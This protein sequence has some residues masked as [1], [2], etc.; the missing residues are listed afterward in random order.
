MDHDLYINLPDGYS[1]QGKVRKLNKAL[2]GLPEAARVWHED[3]EEKLNTLGFSPLESDPGV[4]LCKSNKGIIAINMHIDDGT[5]ICSSK[6]EELELKAGIQKFYKIKEKESSKPFKVLGILVTR[7]THDGTL[8]LSQPE[9]I[10]SML[11]RFDMSNCNPIAKLVDK[12]SHLQG[13]EAAIFA[14]EKLY[15]ALTGSLTY[16]V[17]ST[18][19][20]IGYIM[21]YLSQLNKKLL[22]NN[23][24]VAKRVLCYLKG[25]KDV[26]VVYRKVAKS[27]KVI[28]GM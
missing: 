12:G 15:Q 19:P 3:L 16:A 2:Y 21:Q 25:T 18:Q 14:N 11:K 24:I 10:D 23:W 20:D 6:E 28:L 27:K 1:K 7:N 17:M 5:G 22:L 4:F 8:K 26:G 9:Y 13:T